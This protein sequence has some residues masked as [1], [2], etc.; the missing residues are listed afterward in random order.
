MEKRVL[1]T[2]VIEPNAKIEQIYHVNLHVYAGLEVES[3]KELKDAL[4]LLEEKHFDLVITRSSLKNSKWAQ[5][6]FEKIESLKKKTKIIVIGDG[7][8][9]PNVTVITGSLDL[10]EVIKSSAQLLGITAQDMVSKKVDDYFAIPLEYFELI[11]TPVVDIYW[12]GKNNYDLIFPR[13]K[14]IDSTSYK[15]PELGKFLY[16]NKLDRLK[17]V[18]QISQEIITTIDEKDL[19]NDEQVQALES[20]M[21]VLSKRLMAVGINEAT[22]AMAEKNISAMK[23]NVKK[24]KK[25]SDLLDRLIKNRS[26]YL[27]TH[28]QIATYIALHI[29]K[30]IDWGNPEQ[31]DKVAFICFFH[32]ILLETDAQAMIQGNEELKSSEISPR[33]KALVEKHAQLAAEMICK[34]PHA[35]MGAD[36]IIK[37]H[38]GSLNGV[39]FSDHYGANLSPMAIVFIVAE[40]FTRHVIKSSGNPQKAHI[41]KELRVKFTANRMKKVVDVLENITI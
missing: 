1:K 6:V 14:K 20:N 19:N 27:F 13:D 41:L 40:E 28:T 34:F 30:N 2:L 12:K 35:P 21:D 22:I 15:N 16:V 7:P 31:E 11:E 18:N 8:Y 17:M 32:D 33:E 29:V 10:K 39:G 3:K 25:L 9:P 24:N 5:S 36:Q 37:T 4:T 26:S 23:N 38:H